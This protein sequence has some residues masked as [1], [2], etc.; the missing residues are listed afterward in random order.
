MKQNEKNPH[1][2]Q[3]VAWR[4]GAEKEEVVRILNSP[5]VENHIPEG[6]RTYQ[7]KNNTGKRILWACRR[8]KAMAD[9]GRLD[10]EKP[11]FGKAAEVEAL[12]DQIDEL[13]KLLDF[14]R[15]IAETMN[16]K[17]DEESLSWQT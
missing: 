4:D 14:Y 8:I 5:V 11:M 9:M 17:V 1:R 15:K 16:I 6:M 7:G 3:A 10:L 13:K 2:T 12:E